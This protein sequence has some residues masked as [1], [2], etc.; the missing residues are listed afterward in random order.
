MLIFR[1]KNFC[2]G[3]KRSQIKKSEKMLS[4]AKW[5][6]AIAYL[7]MA[8]LLSF[9]LK[10]AG[11]VDFA[12]PSLFTV[13]SFWIVFESN[14]IG[15][16]SLLLGSCYVACGIRFMFGWIMR[17]MRHGEDRRWH[18]WRRYWRQGE[19]LCNPIKIRHYAFNLYLFYQA[20]AVATVGF[21]M[22]PLQVIASSHRTTFSVLQVVAIVMYIGSFTF[23][24][25]ADLQLNAFLTKH[26][27][28]K[29]CDIGLWRYCRH[30]NYLGEL[31]IWT[32]YALFALGENVVFVDKLTI[33][34]V[35][36]L[37]YWFLV[38]FTGVPITEL[39]SIEHRGE[40]YVAYM[41]RTNMILPKLW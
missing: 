27:G 9:P 24:N 25:V 5:I 20:Q 26:R 30:P 39:A 15:R 34:A 14:E 21:M 8:W 40:A 28:K 33:V 31:G 18:L 11:L 1:Q 36:V 17:T 7:S 16:P 19:Y 6:F 29:V 22:M 37:A 2:N 4:S 41:H 32:S 35:P 23:E 12:W 3:S 38:Y 13:L 10:N